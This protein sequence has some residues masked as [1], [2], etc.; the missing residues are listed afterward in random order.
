METSDPSVHSFIV[1]IWVEEGARAD[2]T[3]AW[4]G[5]ITHVPGG[6]RRYL[7]H[8]DDIVDFIT[9]YLEEMNG[10]FGPC[11]RVRRWVRGRLRQ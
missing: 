3:A 6:E 5:H 2:A 4:R 1:K 8:L 11:G 7:T 10:D 9:P